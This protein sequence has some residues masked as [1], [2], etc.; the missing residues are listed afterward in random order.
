[1]E[2]R[3]LLV[4]DAYN[5]D[6]EDR[7]IDILNKTVKEECV[8]I[9][10]LA[11]NGNDLIELGYKGA[12]IGGMLQNILMSITDHDNYKIKNNRAELLQYS[13][14]VTIKNKGA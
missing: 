14:E 12:E 13:K 1:M 8:C 10:D 11:I 5:K 2:K 4:P 7:S 3:F 6:Y 9:K